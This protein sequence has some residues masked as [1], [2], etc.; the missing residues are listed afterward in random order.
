MADH[1]LIEF[2]VLV[3]LAAIGAGAFGAV[4]GVGGGLI[5]VPLL[6]IFLGVDIKLAIAA[7]LLGVIAVSTTAST[8]Y[9]ARG[10]ADRRLGLVLLVATAAGGILGGYV[11]GLLDG[12]VIAGIFGVVLLVTAGQMSR[13]RVDRPPPETLPGRFEFDSSYLEP[14]TGAEV[15]YRARRVG[16]G[17][18]ISVGAGAL[19][20][21]LGIGGGVVNVPTMNVLMG[22][23]IRVATSTSTYMLGATAVASSVLYYSRGEIDGLLAAPVVVGVLVGARVG[24]RLAGFVPRRGLQLVFALVALVFAVQMML[25]AWVG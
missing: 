9:L 11:A 7:S 16:L 4:V 13:R 12:R 23:P 15:R 8:T 10:W 17:G 22:I 21:L 20:G 14:T 19:S 18:A 25:R 3:L 5:L 1:G 2:E 24:A 6:T